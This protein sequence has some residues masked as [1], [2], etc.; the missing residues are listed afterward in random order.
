MRLAML[1]AVLCIIAGFV[2]GIF[3]SVHFVFDATTWFIA[4]IAFALLEL[5]PVTS[6]GRKE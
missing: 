6:V 4:A 2:V 3:D 5:P 1:A